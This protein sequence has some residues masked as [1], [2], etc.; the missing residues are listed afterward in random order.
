MERGLAKRLPQYKRLKLGQNTY[1]D[2]VNSA[3]WEFTWHEKKTF[4]GPRRA[5]DQIYI[6]E[7]GAEYA[8][9]MS[10]PA[11]DWATTR[12]QFDIMLRGWRPP[13]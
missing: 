11:D 7:D 6:E 13:A 8:L 9:Y 1:R 4:P 5:I 12:Q 3:C 10:G 2:Q